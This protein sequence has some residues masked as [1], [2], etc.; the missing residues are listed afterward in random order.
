VHL[1]T[2]QRHLLCLLEQ[3]AVQQIDGDPGGGKAVAADP[4]QQSRI[5]ARWMIM[6]RASCAGEIDL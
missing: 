2:V 4:R 6:R 3:A 5:L 1:C